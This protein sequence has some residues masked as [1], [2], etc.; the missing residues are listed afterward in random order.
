MSMLLIINKNTMAPVRRPAAIPRAPDFAI[1]SVEG[2]KSAPS[3]L[4]KTGRPSS[5]HI[6]TSIF[7]RLT[8]RLGFYFV[9]RTAHTSPHPLIDQP[10][11]RE[12]TMA[13]YYWLK[14]FP[15]YFLVSASSLSTT[16]FW[17]DR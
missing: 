14:N 10:T 5:T 3:I 17:T 4:E 7:T 11:I 16:T 13:A 1:Q 8:T 9:C 15:T 6:T 2:R 12:E